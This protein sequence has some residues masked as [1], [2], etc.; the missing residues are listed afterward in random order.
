MASAIMEGVADARRP[1]RLTSDEVTLVLRRAAEI[2]AGS[3]ELPDVER[4]DTAAVEEA[5]SEVGLSRAAVRQA[6]AELAVGSLPVE[7]PPPRRRSGLSHV[8]VEQRVVPV[9][10]PAALR[11]VERLMRAQLFEPRRRT[12]D[13]AVFRPRN[14]VVAV[15]RRKLNLGG[16]IWFR[17][18]G[19]VTAAVTP[20][21]E[22]TLVRLDAELATSRSNVM[23][24]AA[25]AGVGVALITGL[26]GA[27]MAEPV[28]VAGAVPAGTVVAAS[29]MRVAGRRWRERRDDVAE[30]LAAI[31]DRL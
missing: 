25:G 14:D 20:V 19:C 13:L 6:V 24:G 8:L 11:G 29:G 31:A 17:G 28:L 9:E 27:L 7:A 3:D 22:G 4:Y 16:A 12:E 2:E 15:A 18:V 23:A 1:V 30:A 26:G 5:A 21:E 10:P